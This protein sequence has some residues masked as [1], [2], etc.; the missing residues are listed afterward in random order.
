MV[1]V[2]EEIS[3]LLEEPELEA[4]VAAVAAGFEEDDEDGIEV[5]W[6]LLLLLLGSELR[7]EAYCA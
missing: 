3:G 7:F 1:E 4:P 5:F 2:A 6:P